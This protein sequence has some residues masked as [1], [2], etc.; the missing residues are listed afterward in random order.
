VL[1]SLD[2]SYIKTKKQHY[3]TQIFIMDNLNFLK[4][5]HITH[6]H[7]DLKKKKKKCTNRSLTKKIFLRKRS[8]EDLG[9]KNYTDNM[10]QSLSQKTSLQAKYKGKG[11]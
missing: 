9:F 2:N 3:Q 6:L 11:I 4:N 8:F 5:F 1:G 7:L 10:K